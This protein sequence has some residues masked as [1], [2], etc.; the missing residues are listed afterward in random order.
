MM[1]ERALTSQGKYGWFRSNNL[2]VYQKLLKK[3]K[4]VVIRP[5]SIIF[6]KVEAKF[7]IVRK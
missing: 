1:R 5:Y 6:G 3:Q 4:F 7:N 2:E